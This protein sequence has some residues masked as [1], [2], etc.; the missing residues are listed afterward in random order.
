MNSPAEQSAL[1]FSS[2]ECNLHTTERPDFPIPLHWHYYAEIVRVLDGSLKIQRQNSSLVLNAGDAILFSPIIPHGLDRIDSGTP[3]TYEIIRLDM[4][5]FGDLP[6]YSPDL[7]GMV[8]E[9]ERRG[10]SMVFPAKL[11]WESHV[12]NMID[13]CVQEFRN[14]HYGYDLRIRSLLYLIFTAFIRFWI[15]DGFVP[16]NYASHIEPLYTLPAYISRHISEPLK[17]EEL[18]TYCGLSYPWF[19]RKFHQTYGISCKEL[20]EK[21]RLRRVEHY[22]QF[23]DCDLNY[24]CQHTGYSDCSHLVRD[25][26]KFHSMTPGKFRQAYRQKPQGSG[27]FPQNY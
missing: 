21:V 20:I 15:R 7:R 26:R 13:Q 9:A 16:Q 27:Q 19:A 14:R 5:Q 2:V 17:V 3:A 10:L 11:L 8:Q 22:L 23:T 18:A 12:D 6:S 25:F 1:L 4:E 24:I